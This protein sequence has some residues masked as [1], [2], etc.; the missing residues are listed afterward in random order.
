MWGKRGACGRCSVGAGHCE[1]GA[2]GWAF[3]LTCNQPIA[4]H[5]SS[6]ITRMD[7]EWVW[8]SISCEWPSPTLF[9]AW[10]RMQPVQCSFGAPLPP[11]LY[12]I[13][14]LF[15]LLDALVTAWWQFQALGQIHLERVCA[16]MPASAGT[17]PLEGVEPYSGMAGSGAVARL[18]SQGFTYRLVALWDHMLGTSGSPSRWAG[19]GCIGQHLV[20]QCLDPCLMLSQWSICCN[21]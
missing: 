1:P 5:M 20:T 8:P 10:L 16:C 18:H 21:Q 6:C 19:D 9:K 15:W 7:C 13:I 11:S 17:D 2:C 3:G 14:S 4:G 12:F